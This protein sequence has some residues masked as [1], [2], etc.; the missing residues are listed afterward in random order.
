M[1]LIKDKV[2]LLYYIGEFGNTLYSWGNRCC[3]E[4][5][6][7]VPIMRALTRLPFLFLCLAA[8]IGLLLRWHQY[9]PIEGVIFPF[10]LHAHSHLMFLGWLF[11]AITIGF[12]V[13]FIPVPRQKI[14]YRLLVLLNLL[15]LLMVFTFPLQ[16]YG[17]YSITVSFLHTL[18]ALFLGWLFFKDTSSRK[19]ELPIYLAQW[20]FIFFFVSSLAP[21][22]IGVL[23]A[24]GQA[25][26][27]AYRL[28][29]YFFLHFQYNGAF[30]FGALSLLFQLFA[31]RAMP[32]DEKMARRAVS[33]LWM[34]CFPAYVLSALWTQPGMVWNIIGFL[35]ASTQL[36][37]LWFL[38]RSVREVWICRASYFSIYTQAILLIAFLS[39]LLKFMLQLISAV[40]SIALL[41][42]EVRYVIIA[43]LHL[44]VVGFLS[45]LMLTWYQEYY[46]T[47]LLTFWTTFSLVGS[48]LFSEMLMLLMPT[49]Y[50]TGNL[51]L[52]LVFISAWLFLTFCRLAFSFFRSAPELKT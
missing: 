32:I 9:S 2:I 5:L 37:A 49:G 46:K 25:H 52:F 51:S 22:A 34:T 26:T 12:V 14:Y 31:S 8:G 29:V 40:P 44:V 16:G 4:K 10:W 7:L 21:V 23:S 30:T 39:L 47:R 28:A 38:W 48:F 41:A 15:V 35:V 13:C 36:V 18:A 24:N 43:Y 27:E 17:P 45:F 50:T 3:L 19:T 20:T 42:S 6:Y 11:N 1:I 33:L